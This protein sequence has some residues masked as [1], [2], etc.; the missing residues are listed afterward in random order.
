M[1]PQNVTAVQNHLSRVASFYAVGP[2]YNCI[3]T[4]QTMILLG[5]ILLSGVAKMNLFKKLCLAL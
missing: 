4:L 2:L 5:E 1:P 3:T